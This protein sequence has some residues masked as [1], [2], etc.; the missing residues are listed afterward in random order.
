MAKEKKYR[1]TS[2]EFLIEL[3]KRLEIFRK[4]IEKTQVEIAKEYGKTHHVTLGLWENGGRADPEYIKFLC[5]KYDAN[6]GFFFLSEQFMFRQNNYLMPLR[7]GAPNMSGIEYK[8]AVSAKISNLQNELQS[9]AE[10]IRTSSQ[11]T[12]ELHEWH[13]VQDSEGEK[14]WYVKR[15]FAE[16]LDRLSSVIEK[17]DKRLERLEKK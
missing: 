2:S 9:L 16:N 8:S 15:D 1:D 12:S 11:Q 4:S 6:P 3:G 5:D 13:N 17:I 10:E 7:A 14:L